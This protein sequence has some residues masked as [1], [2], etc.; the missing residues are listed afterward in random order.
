LPWEPLRVSACIA[1]HCVDTGYRKQRMTG[2]P[3]PDFPPCRRGPT[4]QKV[5]G[6]LTV[7]PVSGTVNAVGKFPRPRCL[8]PTDPMVSL[9]VVCRV[10]RSIPWPPAPTGRVFCA[11]RS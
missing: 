1:S 9:A 6:S 10:F 5:A 3:V 7:R 11:F 8:R 4:V 2:R